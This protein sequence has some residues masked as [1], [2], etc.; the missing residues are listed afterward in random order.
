[1]P[2]DAF[3]DFRIITANLL[4]L[5]K[6]AFLGVLSAEIWRFSIALTEKLRTWISTSGYEW[7]A[8]GLCMAAIVLLTVYLLVRGGFA[9]IKKILKSYRVDVL[10]ALCFGIWVSVVWGGFLTTWDSNTIASLKLAQILT[11]ISGPFLLG[12]LVM[13]RQLIPT[14]DKTLSSLVADKEVK[15]KENDL[16]NFASKADGF[17]ERVFNDGSPESFVF[18]VDAPW[19]I[20]KS[21]FINFCTEYWQKEHASKVVVYKF[22]PLQYLGAENLLEVFI[23]GLIHA[24][25]KDAFI[26][27]IK[28]L[29]SRY[30]RLLKEMKRFSIFGF[31]LPAFMTDYSAEEACDDLSAVLKRFPKKVIVIIDDLD[32]ISFDEI[33]DILFVIRKSFAFPNVSYVICYDTDN[34]GVMDAETP[35][36]EKV[37]EFLEKFVNIK[38]SLF[39]EREDLAKF[40][41]ENLGKTLP[42]SFVDPLPMRQAIGGLLD[43]YNST[44]I[45]HR[46]LPFIGDVRKLKRLINT[47]LMFDLQKTDFKNSDFDKRD[48]VNLL[49]IYIHY[50]NV[51]RKIYDT[52]TKGGRGFFSLVLPHEDGYPEDAPG[53]GR[54]SF[55]DSR[56]K[57]STYYEEYMKRFPD[58]SLQRFLLEQVFKVDVRLK[59]TSKGFSTANDYAKIDNVP[60]DVRTSLACFNG[61]WTNGRNLETYLDLIVNLSRPIDTGQHRFYMTWREAIINKKKSLTETFAD[62]AFAYSEGEYPRERLWRILINNA[63][64]LNSDIA[65]DIISHLLDTISEYSLIELKEEN[66]GTGL[67]HDMD[68]FLTRLL[69]D[70]GWTDKQGKHSGNM[71][72][73][74][75]EIAEWVFGDGRHEG[76]GV[77]TRLSDPARG[78][79][80]IYDL[81]VFRLSCSSDR[82]GDIFDLSRALAQHANQ[83]APTQGDT[84]VIAREEMR[85]ISQKVFGIFSARYI[86]P[87]KN[88][89]AEIDALQTA[90]LA[91]KYSE[92][93]TK[94]VEDGVFQPD[95]IGRKTSEMKTRLGSFILYQLANAEINLGAGCGFYDP[96]G[97][98]DTNQIRN[99]VNDYLFTCFDPTDKKNAEYFIDYLFRNFANAIASFREDGEQYIPSINEF[100]KVMD[101]KKLGAFWKTHGP[102]YKALKLEDKEKVVMVGKDEASYK[103][104]IPKIYDVLDKNT[105]D[106]LGATES[107]SRSS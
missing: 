91:G 74:I 2:K 73:Y 4:V 55:S 70:A 1:M 95:D 49:L 104:Y 103:K 3:S 92:Y 38:I 47:V 85:E 9:D 26:P 76:K 105:T 24:I 84:R 19:G 67:R 33:K 102:A 41:S 97:T 52:E 58:D 45:Y 57:N 48:L 83:N 40:V 5:I 11:L 107:T 72:P 34:I 78:V 96:T 54:S 16:L 101:A 51:F 10:L 6:T 39:L 7:W 56:Y 64:E 21:S 71:E 43:I 14:S 88:I 61:G 100:T 82:G 87:K 66:T 89:F 30:A 93:V 94:K 8:I 81:M 29:I 77:L 44:I 31:T 22:S 75:N 37:G 13:I 62:P 28:P 25:Q 35:E 18:G 20:G 53:H 36:I 27:E 80:G 69:N 90:D 98:K 17:A 79:M 68:F 42:T 32:R 59:M 15:S 12:A 46:Y 65:A 23:D 63:R 50:P 99:L 60:E 106:I 86:V